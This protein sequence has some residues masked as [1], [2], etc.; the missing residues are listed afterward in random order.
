MRLYW[1]SY[2]RFLHTYINT[3]A[4]VC[5][6]LNI[7]RE[8]VSPYVCIH[9]STNSWYSIFICFF[10]HFSYSTLECNEKNHIS[11]DSAK[12]MWPAIF[13]V[14]IIVIVVAVVVVCLFYLS[15]FLVIIS[16]NWRLDTS[17]RR[18]FCR[19]GSQGEITRQ[20][21]TAFKNMFLWPQN[22]R[23]WKCSRSVHAANFMH[24]YHW[25]FIYIGQCVNAQL[26]ESFPFLC[27]NFNIVLTISPTKCA[28]SN[29]RRHW[30]T[31]YLR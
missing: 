25:P 31:R 14:I 24:Y 30:R 12:R 23:Q 11:L 1:C 20:K 29:H 6:V 28:I 8:P 3:C 10:F 15:K 26:N 7:E 13:F 21:Y 2:E 16:W 5:S 19:Y 9:F 4:Q 17:E 22:A 18:L 27:R